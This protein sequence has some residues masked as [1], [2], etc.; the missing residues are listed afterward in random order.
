[1]ELT[2]I[3]KSLLH[4]QC[5]ICNE[6]ELTA[7]DS[8]GEDEPFLWCPNCESTVDSLGKVE[9]GYVTEFIFDP[10]VCPS[11]LNEWGKPITLGQTDHRFEAQMNGD[12][13]DLVM[14]EECGTT[15]E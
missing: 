14:C 15:K 5:T 7:L 12:G 10:E 6:N 8:L 2:P 3:Q 13:V 11:S 1:M 9:R 4:T